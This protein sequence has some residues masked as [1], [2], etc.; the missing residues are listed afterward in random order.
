MSR[1]VKWIEDFCR[2]PGGRHVGEP[3]RLLPF[4][5]E[6]VENIY[7]TPTRRVIVSMARQN[8]K[9]L[10]AA[11]LLLLHLAGERYKQN[12]LCVSTALTRDQAGLLF[13]AA[14]KMVRLSPE[15]SATVTVVDHLKQLR[16]P[17]LGTVYRALS[18]DAPSQLGMAPFFIVHDELGQVKDAAHPLYDAT[19]S[20]GVAQESPLS[21]IISTQAADDLALLS[22]LIDSAQSGDDP[23]TKLFLWSAPED[24]DPFSDDALLAANPGFE[25][26]QN[27]DELRAQAR[28]AAKMPS[29]EPSY[30]NLHLN[31]RIDTSTHFVAPAVWDANGAA[32]SPLDGATVYGG[33]DLASAH[34]LAALV[35]VALDGSVHTFAWLPSEGLAEKGRQDH[36]PYTEWAKQGYLQTTPGPAISFEHIATVMRGIFERCD[37]KAIAFDPALMKHLTPWLVKAG[38]TDAEIEAKFIPYRQGFYSMTAAVRELEVRLLERKLRHGN[39]PVL[40]MCAI[41]AKVDTD[42]SGSRK[43]VKKKSRGRMDAIIALS[44]ACAVMPLVKEE[45]IEYAE[46]RL[47]AF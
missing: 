39:H 13:D 38:F 28:N 26:F 22:R 17:A 21:V 2:V 7:S 12:G 47:I 5:R 18:S 8:G 40:K 46:G 16:C 27:K 24:L 11:C 45:P 41:N 1:D 15:L 4:Q 19:E 37:V 14:A 29:M 30:R 23:A 44:M 36:A 31:Q 25:N 9:T 10:L 42:T 3:I 20:G 6:I 32:P 35:L 43:F 33:L 34:D